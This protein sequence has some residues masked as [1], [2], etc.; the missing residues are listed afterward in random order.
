ML[1]TTLQEAA[2]HGGDQ[3]ECNVYHRLLRTTKPS[4]TCLSTESEAKKKNK[5]KTKRELTWHP[6]FTVQYCDPKPVST[7]LRPTCISPPSF[8]P[9]VENPLCKNQPGSS[10]G[11]TAPA[12]GG[13]VVQASVEALKVRL[14]VIVVHEG[15]GD[16]ELRVQV[17]AGRSGSRRRAAPRV[18]S[19]PACAG[20]NPPLVSRA[21]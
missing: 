15:G 1:S 8:A 14:S 18:E 5:K 11:G 16:Q 7:N 12:V 9:H 2:G 20:T 19:E 4:T 3:E 17:E 21:D 6:T 10:R 13:T